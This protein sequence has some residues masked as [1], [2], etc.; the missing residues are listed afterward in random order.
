MNHTDNHRG[1]ESLRLSRKVADS[2]ATGFTMRTICFVSVND[3]SRNNGVRL[4]TARQLTL[5]RI[6]WCCE[7]G[8]VVLLL[9]IFL[10]PVCGGVQK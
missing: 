5:K 8:C 10:S 1:R 9:A 2:D 7:E 6:L 4:N 3:G